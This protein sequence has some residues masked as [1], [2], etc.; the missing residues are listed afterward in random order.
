MLFRVYILSTVENYH[1]EFSLRPICECVLFSNSCLDVFYKN[2]L[3][4][5][6]LLSPRDSTTTLNGSVNRPTKKPPPRSK[7]PLNR[8]LGIQ[9]RN[10]VKKKVALIMSTFLLS[11]IVW[12]CTCIILVFR[13]IDTSMVYKGLSEVFNGNMKLSRVPKYPF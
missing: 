7:R 2:R 12:N 13:F 10:R 8:W 9:W 6:F 1:L 11:C 4:L 5:K 3:R